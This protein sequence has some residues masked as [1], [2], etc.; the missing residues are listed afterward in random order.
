MGTNKIVGTDPVRII[1]AASAALSETPPAPVSIPLWDGHTA[2][3][4]VEALGEVPARG[5]HS[6]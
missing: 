6:Y 3:R 5:R 2:E 4:I 1:E